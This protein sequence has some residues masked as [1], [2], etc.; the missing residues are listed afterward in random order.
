MKNTQNQ[1]T[2]QEIDYILTQ[3]ALS[4][5]ISVPPLFTTQTCISLVPQGVAI[6]TV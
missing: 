3:S 1:T 6:V 2:G 4:C 5:I